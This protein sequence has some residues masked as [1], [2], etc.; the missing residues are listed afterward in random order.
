MKVSLDSVQF[1]YSLPSTVKQIIF[2]NS[3]ESGST[4]DDLKTAVSKGLCTLWDDRILFLHGFVL[5][6][7]WIKV[8]TY[9]EF[10]AGTILGYR[11]DVW[12]LV[13]R[14]SGFWKSDGKMQSMDIWQKMPRGIAVVRRDNRQGVKIYQYLWFSF[15]DKVDVSF[16]VVEIQ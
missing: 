13:I 10:N 12:I 2:Q 14:Y 1:L 6:G 9:D 8:H 16:W 3:T 5:S 4:I 15:G 11:G 7:M